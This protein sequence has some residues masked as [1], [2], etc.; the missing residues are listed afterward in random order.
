MQDE[1]A[2]EAQHSPRFKTSAVTKN[3]PEGPAEGMPPQKT[4]KISHVPSTQL[5]DI[6]PLNPITNLPRRHSRTHPP[7]GLGKGKQTPE[8]KPH[9]KSQIVVGSDRSPIQTCLDFYPRSPLQPQSPVEEDDAISEKDSEIVRTL[10]ESLQ[11]LKDKVEHL[12]SV[13][14]Q[15]KSNL[16]QKRCTFQKAEDDFK[17]R[18]QEA[19]AELQNLQD[20]DDNETT[21]IRDLDLKVEELQDKIEALEAEFHELTQEKARFEE[22][23]EKELMGGDYQEEVFELIDINAAVQEESSELKE[24]MDISDDLE[25]L[26]DI[27]TVEQLQQTLKEQE[28]YIQDLESSL[29]DGDIDFEACLGAS[30]EVEFTALKN[31][32]NLTKGS[33]ADKEVSKCQIRLQTK[34]ERHLR[35]LNQEFAVK[36]ELVNKKTQSHTSRLAKLQKN[37]DDAEATIQRSEGEFKSAEAERLQV[38]AETEVLR[39][40]IEELRQQLASI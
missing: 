13:L 21:L 29:E 2:I 19:E 7:V 20:A 14:K 38:Q 31:K 10:E 16:H 3:K 36:I 24:Q 37:I 35:A 4:Q 26:I 39:R 33:D 6:T 40:Q 25:Q 11:E 5:L 8:K 27:P 1:N 15:E 22:M 30:I 34:F 9:A 12:S 17:E 23:V 32:Y 28:I 18:L